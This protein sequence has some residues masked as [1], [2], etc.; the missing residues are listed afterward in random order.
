MRPRRRRLAAIEHLG[1][2]VSGTG[3]NHHH[4][5]ERQHPHPLNLTATPPLH[6]NCAPPL[7]Q[8]PSRWPHYAGQATAPCRH[9]SSYFPHRLASM[10]LL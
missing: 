8:P 10:Q 4:H 6:A 2:S 3:A 9:A 1:F 5:Q 7:P